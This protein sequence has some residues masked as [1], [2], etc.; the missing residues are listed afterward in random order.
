MLLYSIGINFLIISSF[1][2][3][4]SVTFILIRTMKAA[5]LY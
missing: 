1:N 4:E 5:Q 2:T 3:I